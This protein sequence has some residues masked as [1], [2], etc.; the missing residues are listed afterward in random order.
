MSKWFISSGR[1]TET[2]SYL[3][4]DRQ[5]H[6]L[7]RAL[8]RS[9]YRIQLCYDKTLLHDICVLN[10]HT[11]QHLSIQRYHHCKKN[12]I[13]RNKRMPW[14]GNGLVNGQRT[15][16]LT[17]RIWSP[18]RINLLFSYKCYMFPPRAQMGITKFSV[19][20]YGF[21]SQSAGLPTNRTRLV[22]Q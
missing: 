17:W 21:T 6:L 9:T 10:C 4:G 7:G 16:L 2:Y 1:C 5:T 22:S 13:R 11:R 12:E 14:N 19:K 8:C 20:P 15:G 18:A 3:R